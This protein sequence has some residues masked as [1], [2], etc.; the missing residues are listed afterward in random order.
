VH[1]HTDATANVVASPLV[2]RSTRSSPTPA[3][4]PKTAPTSMSAPFRRSTRSRRVRKRREF[5]PR[6]MRIDSIVDAAAGRQFNLN[7]VF[8]N[9]LTALSVAW[10]DVAE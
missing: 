6:G 5:A 2:G 4:W 10:V 3:V 9:P 8:S 7:T 1:A